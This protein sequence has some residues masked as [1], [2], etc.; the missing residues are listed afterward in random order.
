LVLCSAKE[1]QEQSDLFD[2]ELLEAR[3]QLR[4]NLSGCIALCNHAVGV[5]IGLIC[6]LHKMS[7]LWLCMGD[8]WV[9]IVWACILVFV[10]L[11]GKIRVG[12]WCCEV[13]GSCEVQHSCKGQCS[14]SSQ[15][16]KTCMCVHVSVH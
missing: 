5:D 10:S 8:V 3:D 7:V 13:V 15:L 2:I 9:G 14:T 12:E 4:T 1:H 11:R 6:V 16:D